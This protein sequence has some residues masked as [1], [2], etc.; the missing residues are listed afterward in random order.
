[1]AGKRGSFENIYEQYIVPRRHFDGLIQ[2]ERDFEQYRKTMQTLLNNM[3][4][5]QT[6]AAQD[7]ERRAQVV[8]SRISAKARTLRT[9]K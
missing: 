3:N 1:V 4:A 6:S 2:A 7:G 8:L 5:A 9:K